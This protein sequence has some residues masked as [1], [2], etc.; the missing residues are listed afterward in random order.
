MSILG[1]EACKALV[2]LL[3]LLCILAYSF[4]LCLYPILW[5]DSPADFCLIFLFFIFPHHIVDLSVRTEAFH[6]YIW[7]IVS[8]CILKLGSDVYRHTHSDSP[9]LSYATP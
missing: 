2:V 6:K 1:N 5:V 9:S 3:V 4:L 7:N 8:I